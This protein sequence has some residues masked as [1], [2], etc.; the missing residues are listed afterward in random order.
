MTKQRIAVQ[1]KSRVRAGASSLKRI[2][3]G[4]VKALSRDELEAQWYSL[5]RRE[6]PALAKAE[7]GWPIQLD[8]CFMRVALD[9]YFGKCWYKVLDKQKGA[10]KSMSDAHL[11]G[12]ISVAKQLLTG[13]RDAVVTMNQRSL[14]F[15]GKHGPMRK[16]A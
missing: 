13:G 14:R 4:S 11:V 3:K 2:R 1:K 8:H 15:R 5:M 12:A 6:L 10:V 9:N 16:T 7:G